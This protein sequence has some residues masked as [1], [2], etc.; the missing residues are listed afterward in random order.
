[1]PIYDFHCEQCQTTSELLVRAS[2]CTPPTC[3]HCGS[4]RLSKQLS[5]PVAPGKSK[6]IVARARARAA[7]EGHFSNYTAG[8]RRKLSGP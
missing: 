2:D 1:M 4:T 7:K 8:E 6:D 5:L 3:P